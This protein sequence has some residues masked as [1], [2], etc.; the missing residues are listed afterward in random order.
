MSRKPNIQAT[1]PIIGLRD[2]IATLPF[3]HA[4]ANI[5]TAIATERNSR[6][7]SINNASDVNVVAVTVKIVYK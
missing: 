2:G 1:T 4:R 5:F 6:S 7:S 3:I